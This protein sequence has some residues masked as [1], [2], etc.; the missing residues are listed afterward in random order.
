MKP[1]IMQGVS[2]FVRGKP[3]LNDV[4]LEVSR[5]ECHGLIGPNG[6]GKSTTISAIIGRSRIDIGSIFMLGNDMRTNSRFA[7]AKV[8]V[9]PQVSCLEHSL[10]VRENIKLYA[11]FFGLGG[12]HIRD[13]ISWLLEKL[14]LTSYADNRISE[15]SGGIKQKISLV[16]ALIN[17][18]ELL[19]LDEPSSN[20]DVSGRNSVIDLIKDLKSR[21]VAILMTSH[22]MEE[23]ELACDRVSIISGG[24]VVASGS[25]GRMLESL[26][27]SVI[28]IQCQDIEQA[29]QILRRSAVECF[30]GPSNIV[31][32]NT[33]FAHVRHALVQSVGVKVTERAASV[34]D[35]VAQAHC[36]M[37][38]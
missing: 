34:S 15:L 19:I 35:L 36:R 30:V 33:T 16:R 37:G 14:E 5:G 23:I 24:H 28:D 38:G 27:G 13:R 9:V 25:V 18:P 32:I 3:I 22:A 8:G 10:S 21:G 4:N 31:C 7:R 12:R 26:G 2:K 6:A 1:I 17:N 11:A 20:L 29:A